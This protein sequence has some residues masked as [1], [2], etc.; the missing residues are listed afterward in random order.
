MRFC[1]ARAGSH[2]E[3]CFQETMLAAL[4][5]YD[6]HAPRSVKSWLFTIAANKIADHHRRSQRRP[7]TIGER[8]LT[9]LVETN[10]DAITNTGHNRTIWDHVRALAP[11]QQQAVTLR[12]LADLAYSEISEVMNISEAAARRNVS[13]GLRNLRKRD[14]TDSLR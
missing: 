13:D 11:K 9:A 14:L 6:K 4:R 7:Q 3:D 10:A 2:A 8:E 5:A 1:A 12:Y